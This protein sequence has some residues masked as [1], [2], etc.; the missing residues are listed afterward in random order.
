MKKLFLIL[1]A[2]AAMSCQPEGEGNGANGSENSLTSSEMDKM[3]AENLELKHQLMVKDSLYNY[4]ASYMNDV[5]E[6]LALIQ[7][8][9]KSLF[10]KKANPEMLSADDP[11]IIQDIEALGVLLNENKSKIAK[12]KAE[13][14]N[15]KTQMSEFEKMIITLSE[16]V[17]TKNMEIFKLQQE[18]ENMDAAFGELFDAFKEKSEVL[19]TTTL[20]LNTAY[21]AYGTKKELVDNKVITSAG[22]VLGI[23][24]NNELAADFN[25]DY[26]TQVNILELKE[27]PL[28]FS[29]VELITTHPTASYELV[30]SGTIQ[31]LVIKDAKSFWSVSKYLVMVVK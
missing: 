21:F 4:Y 6:N 25:K 5:K 14:K 29:K 8:K 30:G 9:Q 18:L 23:G 20:A 2:A 28:G 26:F 22:G 19:E 16:E 13:I 27:I 7:G 24:K 3:K 17:E 10:D 31:K 15:N 1:I 12:L 11:T